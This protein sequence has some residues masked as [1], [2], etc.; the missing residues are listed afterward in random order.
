MAIHTELK[1]LDLE[2]IA[3]YRLFKLENNSENINK[4]A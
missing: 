3:S 2:H 4:Y 1:K